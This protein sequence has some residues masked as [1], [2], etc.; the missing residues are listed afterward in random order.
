MISETIPAIQSLTIE[1]KLLLAG[2]L[3]REAAAAAAPISPAMAARLDE[4]LAAYH[5]RPA[6]VLGTGQVAER[7][8]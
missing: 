7:P 6:E 4:R 2:E 1:E 3:W 8:R 5:E